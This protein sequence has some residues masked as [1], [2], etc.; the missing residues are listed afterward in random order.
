MEE[1]LEAYPAA[2]RAL[3]QRYH[4]GGCSSCG[5]QPGDSLEQV[6]RDHGNLDATEVL[7][8]VKEAQSVE[9][10][11]QSSVR[12]TAEALKTVQG[13]KL[14]DVR[15]PEEWQLAH[16][17]EA[18]LVTQELAVEI[19]QQWPKDTPIVILCHSGIRS[20]DAAAYLS[21]HGFTNVRSMTGGIEAWSAEIDPSVPRY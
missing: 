6:C 18:Q 9:A 3:F 11:M 13:F 15:S 5:F 21:S 1:I 2:Q 12:E 7:T 10:K 4:I 16:L 19:L 20:L 14:L 17:A 8:F